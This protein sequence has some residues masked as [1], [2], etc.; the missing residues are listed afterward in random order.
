MYERAREMNFVHRLLTA[1]NFD[2]TQDNGTLIPSSSNGGHPN[3][4]ND[5]HLPPIHASNISNA[6]EHIENTHHKN[7]QT[8]VEVQKNIPTLFE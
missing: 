7:E 8:I 6:I 3:I 4:T 1:L 5:D 2:F